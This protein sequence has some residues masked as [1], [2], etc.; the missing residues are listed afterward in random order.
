[1]ESGTDC[2][3]SE[4]FSAVTVM[5]SSSVDGAE[6]SAA[7]TRNDPNNTATPAQ[8]RQFFDIP[9]GILP[10]KNEL[11]SH[12]RVRHTVAIYLFA[13]EKANR[14]SACNSFAIGVPSRRRDGT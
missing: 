8:A 4:R 13:S 9:I 1:M 7:N 12:I 3:V 10:A 11:R 6:V 14:C 5:V 2:S